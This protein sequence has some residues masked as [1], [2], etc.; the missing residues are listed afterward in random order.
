MARLSCYSARVL[1]ALTLV[2]AALMPGVAMAQRSDTTSDLA[3]LRG[4]LSRVYSRGGYAEAMQ[5]A[6]K[7]VAV[8]RERHG[9]EHVEFAGAIIWQALVLRALGRYPEAEPLL[10]R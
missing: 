2:L 7:Y 8:A 9:E 1:T 4:E 3:T 6:E 5:L 10:K